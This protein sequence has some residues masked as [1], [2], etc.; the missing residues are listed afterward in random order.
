MAQVQWNSASGGFFNSILNWLRGVLPGAQDTAVL[1]ALGAPYTV[2]S[3]AGVLG[4]PLG[5]TQTVGAIQT[6]AGA[7]LQILGGIDVTGLLGGATN[8][9]ALNGAGGSA[10]LG[11]IDVRNALYTV[12]V[13]GTLL[14]GSANF[15]IGGGVFDNAGSILLDGTPTSALPGADQMAKLSILGPVTLDGGGLITLSNDA[16]NLITGGEG[17]ILTN[18]DNLISGAGAITGLGLINEAAGAINA[19][20]ALPLIL[21]SFGTTVNQGL[22]EATN[23]G[24]LRLSGNI[25]N[26]GGQILADGGR[27]ILGGVTIANGALAAG[28]F[29]AF[30]FQEV[31]NSLTGNG[32]N[33]VDL[34]GLI[35]LYGDANLTITG[36]INNFGELLIKTGKGASTTDLIVGAPGA[37]LS[38]GGQI[39]LAAASSV[40]TGV[41]SGA[42]LTNVDNLI[43]GS[44]LLGGGLMTLINGLEATI[45]GAGPTGLTIDTGANAIQNAGLIAGGRNSRTLIESAVDNSGVLASQGGDLT[46]LGA[47]TGAGQGV[48][49]G[50]ILAFGSSF[51]ENV[52]FHKSGVLQLAQARGYGGLI[53]GFTK[54]GSTAL[55]LRDIGFAGPGEASYSG[56]KSGGVLTVSDGT[57]T[58]QI[59]LIGNYLGSTFTASSDGQRGVDIVD[60][61]APKPSV[62]GF[63]AAAA[64][65]VSGVGGASSAAPA[66]EHG[67]AT[68]ALA[69]PATAMA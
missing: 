63:A 41:T 59:H 68:I 61:A 9:L 11:S 13:L 51:G 37:I 29:S 56:D 18:V 31:G 12:P 38:G 16:F 67:A 65:I 1:G 7:T 39:V 2:I 54:T 36:A 21:S 20:Q 8:F 60:Q 26:T 3:Q 33:G 19:D 55:D 66:C 49:Q 45:R 27:V 44:G 10:N 53:S 5:G 43:T 4:L 62:T 32:L 35:T 22:L 6:T 28:V 47:V 52:T 24:T 17:A 23:G 69:R 57:H 30:V 48:I 50:G 58:A 25:D 64:G 46:V 42:T 15:E 40:I 34:S 14:G